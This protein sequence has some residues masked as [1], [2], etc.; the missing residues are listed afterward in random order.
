MRRCKILS[1]ES[2]ARTKDMCPMHYAR[3]KNG[4]L[5]RVQNNSEPPKC[6]VSHCEQVSQ[7]HKEATPLCRPHYQLKYRGI[8][9]ET[10][11][12]VAHGK[13][14]EVCRFEQ[15]QKRSDTAGYCNYHARRIRTGRIPR[16]GGC[17]IKL[18]DP[19]SFEGC[20]RPYATRKLC[21]SHYSQFMA[22]GS[23]QELR[24]Y[25]KYTR[26]ELRCSVARC[27]KR[28]VSTGLCDNHKSLQVQ[29][30]V[31]P[32]RMVEI[33]ENPRCENPGCPE[34]KRLH[35][36]HDHASGKFRGLL[37]NGCNTGLGL[38]KEDFDR[39]AGIAEYLKRFK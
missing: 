9:P 35:M 18:N 32:E 26:G 6:S 39:I 12:V 3:E 15:C 27:R 14:R 25:D 19:C 30:G 8:D 34:T 28:S 1:C 16:P 5:P 2:A 22:T 24:D 7:G 4:H 37:C 38:L 31:T 21:H 23:T 29:Y 11:V 17:T 13:T 33:W 20:D 10:R 36:D